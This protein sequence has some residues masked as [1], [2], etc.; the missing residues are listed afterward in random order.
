MG[1]LTKIGRGYSS[2]TK[3]FCNPVLQVNN[4]RTNCA[5]TFLKF[6]PEEEIESEM[7]VTQHMI[8]ALGSFCPQVLGY[9]E[10]GECA[11]IHLSLADLGDKRPRGFVD[12]Y[13]E[14]MQAT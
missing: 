4:L 3:Y 14:L 7:R 6:G 12:V 11:A 8:R 5:T 13:T 2:A 10:L 9:A 1:T